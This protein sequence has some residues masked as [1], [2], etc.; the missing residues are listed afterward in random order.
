MASKP[1]A[2]APAIFHFDHQ[3]RSLGAAVEGSLR[4]PPAALDRRLFQVPR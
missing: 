2:S 3:G 1:A 4:Q